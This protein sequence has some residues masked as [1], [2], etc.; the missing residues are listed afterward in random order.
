MVYMLEMGEEV[1]KFLRAFINYK[2]ITDNLAK[3][4]LLTRQQLTGQVRDESK[5]GTKN[6][7]TLVY[8]FM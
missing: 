2:A 1:V 4:G 6:S 5:K 3:L 7:F 8:M